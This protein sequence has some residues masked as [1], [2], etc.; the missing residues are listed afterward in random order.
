M[1]RWLRCLSAGVVLGLAAAA[2][3]AGA[4]DLAVGPGRAFARI[5]DALAGAQPGDAILVY[6]RPGN[7]PYEKTAL[8]VAKPR[9]A[10]RA[11]ALFGG[12]PGATG[13]GRRIPLSGAGFDYSGRGSIPRAIV[14]FNRGADGGLLEGFELLDAH[15]DSSNG[16]GVRIN[17]ANDVTVRR[18]EIH[19][20]DMGI[21]SNGDGT[22]STARNQ[23]I[24]ACLIHS[25][26]SLKEP[27]YN[28]NLYLGGT[29]VRLAAC[30]VHSSLT[31][32]NVKSRAHV[33]IVISC[34]IHD[35]SNR[36]FDLVDSK[37]DTTRP[38][39]DAVLAGNVIVKAPRCAGN[40][41]VIH[42]GQDGGNEHD[43][44]IWLAHNTIVTPFISPVLALSAPRT[45]AQLWNNIVWNG[46]TEQRGQV[47]VDA[48]APGRPGETV[49]G[50]SNWLSGGFAGAALAAM[51]LQ[52][53]FLARPGQAPPFAA[54]PKGDWRL[55]AADASI[56]N[57]GA[58][59]PPALK[60]LLGATLYQYEAPLALEPR[61]DD[62]KPDL[63]AYEFGRSAR[64]KAGSL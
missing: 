60:T 28:H 62:G 26:G 8:Y 54:P 47:L 29:S 2:A 30:E 34:Y 45:R 64:G 20:C 53:T 10:I 52:Q 48:K 3:P 6:P 12:S 25:N 56:V 37:G 15:N 36:E 58:A 1:K 17:Q 24:E 40:K 57:A 44:T 55:A 63:G 46:G 16:A 41:A 14:Q 50:R 9:I 19:A 51:G 11:V 5:E 61:P 59:L 49:Q 21:M 32:H 13:Q 27:G 39:S 22:D 31:G 43:G 38:G 33:T 23:A 35:S 18:C 42:F 7:Q 4:A